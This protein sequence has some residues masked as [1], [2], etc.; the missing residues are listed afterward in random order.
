MICA[1][2]C[3]SFSWG[4][5]MLADVILYADMNDGKVVGKVPVTRRTELFDL[6]KRLGR[7]HFKTE[8]FNVRKDGHAIFPIAVNK[9]GDVITLR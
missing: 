8:E 9:A 7:K 1:G 5:R 4:R 3:G 6:L 2:M